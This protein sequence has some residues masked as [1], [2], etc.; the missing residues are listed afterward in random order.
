M[1]RSLAD[2]IEQY[3]KVLIERSGKQEIEIQRLELAETFSCVPS[4]VTYVLGTRFTE[5]NGFYTCSRRGGKGYVRITRF[6]KSNALNEESILANINSVIGKIHQEGH[7][8]QKEANLLFQIIIQGI[9]NIENEHKEKTAYA[10]ITAINKH[11][12]SGNDV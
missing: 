1:K 11:F 10:F 6:D 12:S 2:K 8:N 7:I 5:E 4:Q 3:I 9:N